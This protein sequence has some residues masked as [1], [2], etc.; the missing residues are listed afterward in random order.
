MPS[1][2]FLHPFLAGLLLAI[3]LPVLGAYLRLRE[4]WLAALAYAHVGAAGA[5]AAT[6]LALPALAGGLSGALLAAGLKNLGSSARSGAALPVLLLLA[7]WSLAVLLAA[8]FPLAERLG[9]ALFDGQ[10]YFADASQLAWVAAGSALL[11]VVLHRLSRRLLLARLYPDFFRGRALPIAPVRFGFDLT[12]ALVL[13]LATT[14]LGVMGAFALVFIPPWL[15]F[16]R[17]RSW[18]GGLLVAVG[19][20]LIAYLAAFAL[21]LHFDQP[22]G[23]VLAGILVIITILYTPR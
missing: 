16:A 5:L 21:A 6:V 7:G 15:A 4:E 13:M 14:T 20:G 17:A 8:N 19:L 18:R 23:P 1:D 3:L 2:L 9:H 11:V 10:L 22:F 12:A